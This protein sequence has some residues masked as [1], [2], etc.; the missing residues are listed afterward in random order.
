M[1]KMKQVEDLLALE[2]RVAALERHGGGGGANSVPIATRSALGGVKADRKPTGSAANG[3]DYR[4]AVIDGS[5]FLY[6]E[7]SQDAL[8]EEI[9][10]ASALAGQMLPRTNAAECTERTL[11]GFGSAV[12]AVLL[13]DPMDGCSLELEF[14]NHYANRVIVFNEREDAYVTIN[15]AYAVEGVFG[16]RVRYA[17]RIVAESDSFMVYGGTMVTFTVQM[18]EFDGELFAIVS[19]VRELV[20]L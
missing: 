13:R 11:V 18:M 5:G 15:S 8:R 19:D 17:D 9:G 2:Q 16:E 14:G 3:T 6:V 12:T 4:Q 10:E 1:L 20:Q 7:C